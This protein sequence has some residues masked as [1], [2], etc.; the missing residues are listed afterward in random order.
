M[1]PA[2]LPAYVLI[3]ASLVCVGQSSSTPSHKKASTHSSKPAKI[4]AIHQDIELEA[5]ADV[6][7]R[8]IQPPVTRDEQGRPKRQTYAELEELEGP[9]PNVPGFAADFSALKTGRAVRVAIVKTGSKTK[10]PPK[11]KVESGDKASAKRADELIGIL[12]KVDSGKRKFTVRVESLALYGSARNQHVSKE[13]IKEFMAE[14]R[15]RQILILSPGVE[16]K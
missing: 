7:V 9:D 11:A 6:E 1:N 12:T 2:I 16:Q 14:H 15:V 3:A 4:I 13:S 10:T 5:G 8:T